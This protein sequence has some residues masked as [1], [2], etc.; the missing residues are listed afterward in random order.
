MPKDSIKKTRVLVPA[1]TAALVV[2]AAPLLLPA[3]LAAP[4]LHEQDCTVDDANLFCEF[5]VSGLGGAETAE[6]T[7]TGDASVTTGC[8]NRG[9]NEPSGLERET[10]DVV[11]SA[12]VNVEGGRAT[13]TLSTDFDAEELRDCPSR[14]MTETI[15]C[16]EFTGLKLE[17]DPSSGP[18]R[19]FNIPDEGDC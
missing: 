19:T 17:V 6:G 14:Q 2:M 5:D 15:V 16:A 7:L 3:A 12:E 4:T 1:I 9:D 8:I 13:F 11:E 10:V 18:S